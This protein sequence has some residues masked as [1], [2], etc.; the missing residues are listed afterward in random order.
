MA[1]LHVIQQ[2]V[3]L[4]LTQNNTAS[5]MAPSR[6]LPST[7]VAAAVGGEIFE[8]DGGHDVPMDED[9]NSKHGPR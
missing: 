2:I 9:R 4:K 6:L 7:Q 1:L 8:F 5:L 3:Y